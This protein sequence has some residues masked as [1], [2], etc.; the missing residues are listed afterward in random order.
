MKEL[1]PS[2]LQKM[3]TMGMEQ[4][5]EA[6]TFLWKPL[7][8]A[9]L[10]GQAFLAGHPD[11]MEIPAAIRRAFEK[12]PRSSEQV[13]HPDKYWDDAQRDEPRHV[14]FERAALPAGWE[15]RGE[16]GL[17]ELGLGFVV[18]PLKSRGGVANPFALMAPR[19]TWEA[20]EGWG[21]DRWIL[22]ARGEEDRVLVLATVWDTP[23]DAR[24]FSAAVEELRPHILAGHAQDL[25]VTL[26]ESRVQVVATRGAGRELAEVARAWARFE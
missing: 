24:E 14:R 7:I 15:V 3:A 4:L 18:E 12:P 6:P 20:S 23:E 9:Y 16:N 2:E 5:K 11:G 17:G 22:L 8:G 21:G 25:A 26:E 19:L 1:D 10:K 13:L